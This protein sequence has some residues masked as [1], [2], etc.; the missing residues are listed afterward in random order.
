MLMRNIVHVVVGDEDADAD[1]DG[2]ADDLYYDVLTLHDG[3][4]VVGA[5]CFG[6]DTDSDGDYALDADDGW[7]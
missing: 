1:V 2:Y 4:D 7:R 5:V 3:V 6:V